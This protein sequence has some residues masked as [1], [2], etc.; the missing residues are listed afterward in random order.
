MKNARVRSIAILASIA[1]F[2]LTAGAGWGA[3]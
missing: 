2:L 3:R 1:S